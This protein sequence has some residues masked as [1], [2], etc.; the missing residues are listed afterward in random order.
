MQNQI[1]VDPQ[2][3]KVLREFTENTV[4]MFTQA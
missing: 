1:T 3:T 2:I 4:F